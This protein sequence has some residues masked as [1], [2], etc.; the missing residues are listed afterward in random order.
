MSVRNMPGSKGRMSREGDDL[1]SIC[2]PVVYK[3]WKPGR[4]TALLASLAC[5]RCD[6]TFNIVQTG[7][8][9]YLASIWWEF[10]LPGG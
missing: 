1:I 6:S 7:Y 3:I 9:T 4:L 5:C 8:E 10:A 2:E